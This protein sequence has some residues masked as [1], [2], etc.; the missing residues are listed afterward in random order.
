MVL[1]PAVR[2]PFMVYLKKFWLGCGMRGVYRELQHVG[3]SIAAVCHR[4]TEVMHEQAVFRDCPRG[5]WQIVWDDEL[6]RLE[7]QRRGLLG[8]QRFLRMLVKSSVEG[9]T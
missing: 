2:H 3:Q 8:E 5:E 4:K 6:V 9:D 1:K 7:K